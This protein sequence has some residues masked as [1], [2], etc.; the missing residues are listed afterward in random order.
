M[1]IDIKINGVAGEYSEDAAP[2]LGQQKLYPYFH[3]E[4]FYWGAGFSTNKDPMHFEASAE[5]IAKWTS[6]TPDPE[7]TP[8]PAPP[9]PPAMPPYQS[10]LL[11][12]V[13]ALH[14][15]SSDWEF[16]SGDYNRDGYTDIIG[17]K[18]SGSGT[19]STEIHILGAR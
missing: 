12:T 14:E 13:T 9:A 4:G 3:D 15:T 11:H 10:W 7:P 18:K 2:Q 1:A 17:I 6:P 8:P 16:S 19:K 5:Q